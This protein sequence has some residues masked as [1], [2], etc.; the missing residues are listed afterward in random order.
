MSVMLK[1]VREN[2]ENED[3]HWVEHEAEFYEASIK[4]DAIL[5]FPWLA[6][7]KLGIFPHHKALVEDSPNLK[8]LYGTRDHRKQHIPKQEGGVP[9]MKCLQPIRCFMRWINMDYIYP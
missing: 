4:V 5:S 2:T 7:Q 3:S 8:F 1:M 6:E 9:Y